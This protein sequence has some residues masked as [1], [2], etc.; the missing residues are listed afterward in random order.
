MGLIVNFPLEI[1]CIFEVMKII[2]VFLFVVISNCVA[3][4][5]IK[6]SQKFSPVTKISLIEI[7]QVDI[8]AT[9]LNILNKR[10]QE[11]TITYLCFCRCSQPDYS[12]FYIDGTKYVNG[13]KVIDPDQVERETP[14]V[15][16]GNRNRTYSYL[17]IQRMPKEEN[18]FNSWWLK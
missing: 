10:S 6:P 12:S 9:E 14:F 2:G 3:G 17:D 7:S 5:N 4:Q 11:E 1:N 13:I 16:D 15:L 18:L 8:H